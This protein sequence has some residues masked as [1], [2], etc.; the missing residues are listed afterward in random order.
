[1]SNTLVSYKVIPNM[2]MSIFLHKNEKTKTF[3]IPCFKKQW[4]SELR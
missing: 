2:H 1:M 3:N 4:P